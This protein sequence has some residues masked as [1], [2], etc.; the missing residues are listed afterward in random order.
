M[1]MHNPAHPGEVL[2]DALESTPM[3][4]TAFAKHIGVLAG[5]TLFASSTAR[6]GSLSEMSIKVSEAFGQG[7][8]DLWF[9][10][11]NQYDFWQASQARG[12]M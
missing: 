5:S 1:P 12:S 9:K 3:T 6:R 4:V 7:S 8:P 2:K 11:Q 10:M